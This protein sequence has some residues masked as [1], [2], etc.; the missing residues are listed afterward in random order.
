MSKMLQNSPIQASLIPTFSR[1]WYPETPVKRG[2]GQKGR[3]GKGKGEGG[4]VKAIGRW[5]PQTRM[6]RCNTSSWPTLG[7]NNTATRVILYLLC[8][9][10]SDHRKQNR[11]FLGAGY[12]ASIVYSRLLKNYFYNTYSFNSSI[13]HIWWYRGL[14]LH[15]FLQLLL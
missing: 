15:P 10:T 13:L 11:T 7:L 14:G 2:R 6:P 3:E 12:G 4:C 8:Q 5:S 9:L 1:G